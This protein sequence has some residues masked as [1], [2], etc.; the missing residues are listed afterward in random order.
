[1]NELFFIAQ[2]GLVVGSVMGVRRLG[3]EAIIM[4]AALLAVFANF[5]VLKQIDLLGWTVTCSDAYVVGHL[6]CLN[7]LQQLYGKESAAKT[8][9]ISFA[10]ML[11]FAL[12]SQVHLYFQPSV[13][14]HADGHYAAL[15]GVAPRLFTASLTTFYCVQ[16][17]DLFLFGKMMNAFPKLSWK[18]RSALSLV[19]SQAFDTLLFT[20]LGLFGVVEDW[21]SIFWMSFAVKCTVIALMA[22]IWQEDVGEKREV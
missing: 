8:I 20:L 16:R 22:V 17:L 12:F 19:I 4:L 13:F 5:F 11:L 10:A 9:L 21:V 15:L 6:L 1:M 2:V 14:D 7:L 3:K 18:I